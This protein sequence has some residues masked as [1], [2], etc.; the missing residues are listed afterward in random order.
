MNKKD[1]VLVFTFI[2][3]TTILVLSM[4]I[5]GSSEDIAVN[6]ESNMSLKQI[7]ASNNVPVKEI[8]HILSHDDRTVWQ[9]P[10]GKPIKNIG[11]DI[12][13]LE[14]AIK[15]VREETHP[16]IDMSKYILW[17]LLLGY[18]LL[19]VLPNKKI[20]KKRIVILFAVVIIFGI[21]LGSTPNPMES[22]VKLIKYFNGMEGSPLGLWLSFAIFTLFSLVG[23][24]L[25]CGWGCQLG[26][27][28][29]ILY[30]IPLFK[31]KFSWKVPF[32]ISI[33]IRI[34][35]FTAF[36]IFLFG[37]GSEVI[38]GIKNYV[39]YHQVNYFKIFNFHDI[40][41]IALLS[42]PIFILAS[43]LFFRPFCHFICP[44]GLYSW[45]LESLAIKKIYIKE[46]DCIKCEKCIKAC[47]TEAMKDIYNKQRKILL[48]DCWSCGKCIDACSTGAIHYE[49]RY[50]KKEN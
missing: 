42:F 45:I 11:I 35:V 4:N 27:L 39:I 26:A 46:S 7:A 29:E 15:H 20:G 14:E 50:F 33:F 8:L 13:E 18:V 17:A 34:T 41:R 19:Y 38:H 36:L 21:I 40:A 5:S 25:I 1:L 3:L 2:L 10:K 31:K 22:I 12:H 9:L 47:P 48:P 44:F 37:L 23:T 24:R 49:Y 32:A 28:Q 30:N 43:I 16:I 6:I